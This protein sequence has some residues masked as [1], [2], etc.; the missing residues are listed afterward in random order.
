M[1]SRIR[2]FALALAGVV[3]AAP[4]LVQAK[5][6]DKINAPQTDLEK[7]VRHE[8][9]ML[10]YYNIFDNLEFKVEGDHVTLMG[11]VTRPTLKSD[12]GNV[13]KRVEG[14]HGVTNNIEVLPL[15]PMDDRIR[16]AT[17]R[18][19]YHYPALQRYAM[20]AVPSIHIIVK[21][22]NVTLR[23][24]VANQTDKNIAGIRANGVFGA[25]SVTNDLQVEHR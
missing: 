5:V 18:S 7:E 21:N 22:G 23:G 16:F 13:V 20:G 25:F 10:P 1:R 17:Y 3:F 9:V 11:E 14:V 4:M 8:L 2:S 6:N 24:V 15:S 12:A 19:I